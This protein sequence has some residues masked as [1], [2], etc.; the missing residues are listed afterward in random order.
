MTQPEMARH[1]EVARETVLP[2]ERLQS[3]RPFEATSL[4]VRTSGLSCPARTPAGY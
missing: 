4:T 1:S 2:I 3:W